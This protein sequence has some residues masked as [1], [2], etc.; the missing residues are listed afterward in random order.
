MTPE[1]AA[2]LTEREIDH[3]LNRLAARRTRVPPGDVNALAAVDEEI[4]LLKTERAWRA[5]LRR[6]YARDD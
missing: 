2:L 5:H 6:K 3:A 4:S 1:L